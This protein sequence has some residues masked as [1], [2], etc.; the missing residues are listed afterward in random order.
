MMTYQLVVLEPPRTHWSHGAKSNLAYASGI[1]LP[2]NLNTP[3]TYTKRT[4][5]VTISSPVGTIVMT[6]GN[7]VVP[8]TAPRI[9]CGET[10]QARSQ[11]VGFC[12]EMSSALDNQ[13]F[14]E[15][16]SQTG[17]FLCFRDACSLV[18]MGGQ[19]QGRFQLCCALDQ[20]PH[21]ESG[22]H[23]PTLPT[24]MGEMKGH[25]G[26]TYLTPHRYAAGL[27][28][29]TRKLCPCYYIIPS[30]RSSRAFLLQVL[31]FLGVPEGFD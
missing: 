10:F 20:G 28:K 23:V 26:S 3:S 15:D 12:G 29:K 18:S 16:F 6:S 27:R 14:L 17:C 11:T 21:E 22:Q 19:E 13:Q 30:S 24:C 2:L 5:I 8:L 4:W 7:V 31:C 9:V 1:I 25:I